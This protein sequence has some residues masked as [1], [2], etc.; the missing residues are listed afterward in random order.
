LNYTRRIGRPGCGGLVVA[1][2]NLAAV[3]AHVICGAET[4]AHGPL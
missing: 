1:A 3:P 2:V 4:P